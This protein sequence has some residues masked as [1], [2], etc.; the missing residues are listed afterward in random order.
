MGCPSNRTLDFDCQLD[1]LLDRCVM[2]LRDIS[3]IGCWTDGAWSQWG[4]CPIELWIMHVSQV[5]FW[6]NGHAIKDVGHKGYY[7]D[8]TWG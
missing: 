5:G 8:G 3:P 6:T 2:Q 1:G 7:N 4:D